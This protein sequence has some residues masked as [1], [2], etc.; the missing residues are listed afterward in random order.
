MVFPIL[1]DPSARVVRDYGVF[2]LLG[3]RLATASTFILNKRGTIR[4]KY[5]GRSIYDRPPVS[6]ILDQLR[7]LNGITVERAETGGLAP[8][9]PEGDPKVGQ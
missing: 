2:D 8:V 5:I 9:T 3:D 1:Y 7:L 4:W 6:T